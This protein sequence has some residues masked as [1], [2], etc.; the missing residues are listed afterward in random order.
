MR[1]SALDERFDASKA[2]T[3]EAWRRAMA[4]AETVLGLYNA[5]TEGG[6]N[7]AEGKESVF[8]GTDGDSVD[9]ELDDGVI[10]AAGLG[11]VAEVEDV[12]FGGVELLEEVG[13]AEFFIHAGSGDID[14][15]GATDFIEEIGEFFAA[16]GDDGFAF[17]EVGIP[18]I[19]SFGAGSLTEGRES[20][21]G[22][23]IFDDF[24]AFSE[25]VGF[26]IA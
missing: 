2:G 6:E 17:F 10:V 14:R 1:G 21:L 15:G 19:F 20:D 12:G 25:L 24:V 22:E 23:A 7:A 18:G 4:S 3:E 16:F 5:G 9:A 11:H 8:V 26:P 13:H